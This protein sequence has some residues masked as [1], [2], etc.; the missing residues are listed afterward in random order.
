MGLSIR[1]MYTL[2]I[3]A[4]NALWLVILWV[5]LYRSSRLPSFWAT[6]FFRAVLFAWLAWSAFPYLGELP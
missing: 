1:D 3:C 4:V 2:A 6:L 5:I